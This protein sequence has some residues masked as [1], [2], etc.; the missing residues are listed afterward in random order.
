MLQKI[1]IIYLL[2][3][4]SRLSLSMPTRCTS[5]TVSMRYMFTVR[6]LSDSRALAR[7][8]GFWVQVVCT[9]AD[10]Y[11]CLCRLAERTKQRGACVDKSSDEL[12]L[13]APS[14]P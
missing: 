11:A 4:S 6:D 10:T 1:L 3:L 2:L 7:L 8:Q 5:Q 13:E 14:H 9:A 12:H